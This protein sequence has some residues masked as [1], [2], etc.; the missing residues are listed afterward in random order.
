MAN[1][2]SRKNANHSHILKDL[3]IFHTYVDFSRYQKI[4]SFL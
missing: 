2:I 3:F 1:Q 4:L